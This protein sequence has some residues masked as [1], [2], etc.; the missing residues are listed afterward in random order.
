MP[1]ADSAQMCQ[2]DPLDPDAAKERNETEAH[3]G[4]KLIGDALVDMMCGSTSTN[5]FSGALVKKNPCHLGHKNHGHWMLTSAPWGGH[6]T[7]WTSPAALR[8]ITR[9]KYRGWMKSGLKPWLKPQTPRLQG[10]GAAASETS[11][12]HVRA[13]LCA[14]GHEAV[15]WPSL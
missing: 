4:M 2:G 1:I 10:L 3:V 15:S 13:L 12:I 9:T 6:P 11:S 5:N 14:L 8:K 7:K